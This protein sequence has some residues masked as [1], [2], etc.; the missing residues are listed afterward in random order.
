MSSVKNAFCF[1]HRLYVPKS[2]FNSTK[3]FGT[4]TF[5]TEPFN[6]ETIVVV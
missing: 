3:G 4:C 6:H 2:G 5:I 1:T